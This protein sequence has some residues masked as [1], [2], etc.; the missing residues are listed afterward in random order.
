ME[1]LIKLLGIAALGSMLQEFEPYQ[2]V[3]ERLGMPDKPFRCTVC[4]TFWY[5][6][7]V[8]VSIY[9]IEGVVYAAFS[10]AASEIIDQ[11]LWKI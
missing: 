11:L 4:A 7:G 2:K 8:L 9:G 6:V 1:L 3:T 10:A 5:S